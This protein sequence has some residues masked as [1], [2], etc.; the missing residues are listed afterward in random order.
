M[1]TLQF[2]RLYSQTVYWTVDVLVHTWAPAFTCWAK[3]SETTWEILSNNIL[4]SSGCLYSQA[5]HLDSVLLP[6]PSI[7]YDIRVH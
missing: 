4:L 6:P 2:V 3:Y 7:M 1:R 5:L